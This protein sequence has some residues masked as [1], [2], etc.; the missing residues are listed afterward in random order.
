MKYACRN[1]SR[2]V[3]VLLLEF[4]PSLTGRGHAR[5]TGAITGAARPYRRGLAGLDRRRAE[6]WPFAGEGIDAGL[7]LPLLRLLFRFLHLGVGQHAVGADVH[8][9]PVILPRERIG[10]PPAQKAQAR[11]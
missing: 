9:A 10:V 8:Q 1:S 2:L 7:L 11:G 6:G 5:C 3:R 4:T